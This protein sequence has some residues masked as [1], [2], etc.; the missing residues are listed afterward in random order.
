MIGYSWCK[1]DKYS[2]TIHLFFKK[3]TDLLINITEMPLKFTDSGICL[4]KMVNCTEV[5]FKLTNILWCYYFNF[6]PLDT[7]C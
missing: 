2:N 5:F 7:H 1:F 4:Q 6:C 3:I